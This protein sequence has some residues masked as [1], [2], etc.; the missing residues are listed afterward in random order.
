MINGLGI[1]KAAALEISQLKNQGC[2]GHKN[3]YQKVRLLIA[4]H[5]RLAVSTN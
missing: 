2:Y 1:D 5:Q 3:S 4:F